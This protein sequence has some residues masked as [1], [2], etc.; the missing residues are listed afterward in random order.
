MAH[1]TQTLQ[2]ASVWCFSG[3]AVWEDKVQTEL[4]WLTLDCFKHL[5][6]PGASKCLKMTHDKKQ[7]KK[8][9]C[10][11][12]FL[13]SSWCIK[14]SFK[15]WESGLFSAGFFVPRMQFFFPVWATDVCNQGRKS[16]TNTWSLAF[17]AAEHTV[18]P[19]PEQAWV[20]AQMKIR[21][22]WTCFAFL[23]NWCN[24]DNVD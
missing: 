22:F 10:L 23:S 13:V 1:L 24:H 11:C 21:L 18:T 15:S 16:P 4:P 2:A 12:P 14:D 5:S 6:S 3:K 17:R 8:R 9:G 7:T 19:H 20:S